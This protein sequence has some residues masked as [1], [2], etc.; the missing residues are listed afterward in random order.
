MSV[1]VGASCSH[2]TVACRPGGKSGAD[3][4]AAIPR[5]QWIAESP[6]AFA[7]LDRNPQAP[8]HALVISKAAISTILA[9]PEPLLGEMLELAKVVAKQQGMAT[10]GFRIVINT[11]PDGGQ[12]VYHVHMHVLGGRQMQWPPG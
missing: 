8:I 5:D 11:L 2:V 1:V 9:A 10:S 3:P 7:I 12:S 4:F 6:N